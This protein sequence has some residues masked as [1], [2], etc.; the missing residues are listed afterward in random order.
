MQKKIFY[1]LWDGILF[2]KG[3]CAS[4]DVEAGISSSEKLYLSQTNQLFH[5][6]CGTHGYMV[7]KLMNKYLTLILY[8]QEQALCFYW[9]RQGS[10]V[11]F[12]CSYHYFCKGKGNRQLLK[13]H[14]TMYCREP[15][16]NESTRHK[17][18]WQFF[19]RNFCN[20]MLQYFTDGN[21]CAIIFM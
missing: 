9:R 5:I 1:S 4:I 14:L 7:N 11:G 19:N 18:A 12:L 6:K 3:L 2:N 20:A 21:F 13:L 8:F 15:I 10:T 16:F 17:S